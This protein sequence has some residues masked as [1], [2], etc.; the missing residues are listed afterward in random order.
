[1]DV[2]LRCLVIL[3][4]AAF[5]SACSSGSKPANQGPVFSSGRIVYPAA[6]A[7]P[8]V[9]W[10]GAIS[11]RSDV[12]SRKHTLKKVLVGQE[13]QEP[14][15]MAPTAVA[16]GPDGTLYVVDQHLRGVAIINREQRRFELFR[17]SSPGSLF[18]P[19]GVAV[20]E[21]G[22]LYVNRQTIPLYHLTQPLDEEPCRL[23]VAESVLSTPQSVVDVEE[24]TLEEHA[25]APCHIE[26]ADGGSPLQQL[27]FSQ[28]IAGF[29][30]LLPPYRSVSPGCPEIGL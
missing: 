26:I 8:V 19:V 29:S 7:A 6:P 5:V 27:S 22:T 21:D 16:I 10:I 30:R 28:R 23:F 20:A 13:E 1:M 17:G 12:D 4:L 2:R 25:L 14:S 18:E 9:E 24:P 3:T 15:L 11:T